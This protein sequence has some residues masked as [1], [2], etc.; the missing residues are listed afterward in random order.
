MCNLLATH[1]Y[2]WSHGFVVSG[3]TNVE[4]WLFLGAACQGR[5]TDL[6]YQDLDICKEIHLAQ[7]LS[8]S[9]EA[10]LQRSEDEILHR[11]GQAKVWSFQ[12]VGH[13]PCHASAVGRP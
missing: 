9:A 8:Q 7:V 3:I 4:L 10:V 5:D 2:D 13:L 1:V 11:G 12:V 6:V